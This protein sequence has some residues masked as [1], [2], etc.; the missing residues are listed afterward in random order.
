MKIDIRAQA[1]RAVGGPMA[2]ALAPLRA[3]MAR[4]I[5]DEE[6]LRVAAE[7]PSGIGADRIEAA[8]R[9][10]IHWARHRAGFH[11]PQ[12]AWDGESFECMSGGRMA[13]AVRLSNGPVDMWAFRTTD[14]DKTVAGRGWTTEVV[15]GSAGDGRTHLGLRLLVSTPEDNLD[16]DVHV[17]GFVGR[18]VET[19]GLCAGRTKMRANPWLISSPSD[20]DEL[21]DILVDPERRI[22]VF[23]ASGDERSENPQ[24]PLIDADLLARATAG[25][26]LV[27]IL[28]AVFT[29]ALTNAVGRAKSVYFGSVRT[30]LPGFSAEADPF[31]HKIFSADT[32]R[33]EDGAAKCIALLR[34]HAARESLLRCRLNKDVVTFGSVRAAALRFEREHSRDID[35]DVSAAESLDVAMARIKSLEA[36]ISNLEEEL[37]DSRKNADFFEAFHAEAENRAQAAEMQLR[38]AL[39]RIAGLEVML[40]EGGGDIDAASPAPSSVEDLVDWCDRSLAGRL[41]ISPGA[42]R[43]LRKTVYDDVESAVIALKWLAGEC[44]DR[45]LAGGGSLSEFVFESGLRNSAC[46]SDAYEFEF[47]GRRLTADWHI[48]NGGN[49]RDPRRCLRIYYGWDEDTQQIVVADMPE[50]RR[51]FIS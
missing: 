14:P 45:R 28:P 32:L 51:N 17:P 3:R 34:R 16:I 2:M 21:V 29:Y 46:G 24:A 36:E 4:V 47:Q 39:G 19:Y 15:I 8:R 1:G 7:F 9:D 20:V 42:R 11:F 13:T 22:S 33:R 5:R 49:T 10:I 25:L 26:A 30:Y 44:R 40:R 35:V 18:L 43:S 50:H 31:E 23:V 6:I 12:A 41:A 37:A 27:V 38:G 48:K